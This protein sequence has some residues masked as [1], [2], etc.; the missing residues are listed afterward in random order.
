M[1]DTAPARIRAL[2]AGEGRV[3]REVRMNAL[4]DSPDSFHETRA[5]AE[6]QLDDYWRDLLDPVSRSDRAQLLIAEANPSPIGL[7]FIRVDENLVGHVGSMWVHPSHRRTGIGR[8]LLSTATTF[9]ERVG[10]ASMELWVSAEDP[11]ARQFYESA[12]YR[13]TGETRLLR[14]GSGV[15]IQHMRRQFRAQ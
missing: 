12:G 13:V 14:Q 6:A 5:E 2:V 8:D 3:L 10:A 1:T 9:A 11:G 4:A 15:Q 7:V